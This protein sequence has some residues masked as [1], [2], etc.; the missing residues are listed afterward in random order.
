[1][2]RN[3]IFWGIILLIVGLALLLNALGVLPG[4]AGAYLWPLVLVLIG[5]FMLLGPIMRGRRHAQ[6]LSVP[7]EGATRARVRLD[8]GA[9]QL[10][11]GPTSQPGLLLSGSFSEGAENSVRRSG[12]EVEVVLGAFTRSTFPPFFYSGGNDWQVELARDVPIRLEL[13]TGAND[14]RLDLTE[15]TVTELILKTGA[16][17][18]RILLPAHAGLTQVEVSSGA[19][20]VDLRVPEG[21][22]ARIRATG[23]LSGIRV[24][25]RRFPR[26]GDTFETPG[27]ETAQNRVE[28]RSETGVGSVEIH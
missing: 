23:G 10:S 19:A 8:H 7:L 11:V 12:G 28:I 24:D 26:V 1:M 2:R 6:T 21:V 18:T 25:S 20:S 13:N 14:A 16:S 5:V 15:L 4:D 27:Y 3:S 17:S 9:G 22:A